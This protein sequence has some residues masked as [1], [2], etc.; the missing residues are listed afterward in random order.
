MKSLRT[1]LVLALFAGMAGTAAAESGTRAV[2]RYQDG[3]S[4]EQVYAAF[5]KT[6]RIACRSDSKILS[7]KF[8][9][10]KT[11]EAKMLDQ[12]VRQ[13]ARPDL[14]ALHMQVTG[15]PEP[16]RMFASKE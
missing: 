15:A 5:Q 2:F 16:V 4:A 9:E 14:A 12:A 7:I 13:V 1:A 6:A 10:Q 3:Q 8:R 11:C